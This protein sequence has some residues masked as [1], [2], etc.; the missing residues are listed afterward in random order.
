MINEIVTTFV[1][2]TIFAALWGVLL[3]YLETFWGNGQ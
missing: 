1:S 3:A 2:L